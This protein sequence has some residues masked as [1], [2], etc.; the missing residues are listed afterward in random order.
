MPSGAIRKDGP[1]AGIAMATAIVSLMTKRAI[2]K[3]IGMTGEITLRGKVLE[4]GGIKEKILAAH[5]AGLK[6]IILPHE[7]KKDIEEDIPKEIQ[8]DL[9]FKFVKNI[10]E[11]LRLALRNYL[12]KA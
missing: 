2:Y 5:R 12:P 1:S 3:H 8:K 11:V 7:N 9:K 6:M 10:D 4:I